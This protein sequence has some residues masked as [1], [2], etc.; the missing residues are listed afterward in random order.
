[1]QHNYGWQWGWFVG[2]WLLLGCTLTAQATHIVGGDLSLQFLGAN[3]PSTHRITLNFYFD[4]VNGNAT[5]RNTE[6]EVAIFSKRTNQLITT[7]T[8]PLSSTSL[9]SYSNQTCSSQ[10]V[11]TQLLVYTANVSLLPA[12]YNDAGGYYISWERCCRNNVITNIINPGAAGSAF[13]LEFPA[14]T[15]NGQPFYDSSPA[16]KPIIGDYACINT[17]F[18][19]D[20]S[21]T[22]ADGD[23]LAYSMVTPYNGFSSSLNPLPSAPTGLGQQPI[24]YAGPYPDVAWS[25]GINATNSIPGTIPLRVNSRTGLLTLV[26]SRTGL[27][28]FSV[29]VDE[30]RAGVKIGVVRRDFQ[31]LVV[32]CPKNAAPSI[33]L[34]VSGQTKFYQEGNVLTIT[35]ADTNC[36]TL[37]TTDP[38]ISQI[39]TVKNLSGSLPGL[40]VG[41]SSIT[42]RT[43][44]DTLITQFCF[45]RCVARPD[46]KPVT[47]AILATDN[48]CPQGRADTLYVTLNIIAP[49]Y[50]KPA[51]STNL[52]GNAATVSVGKSLSFTAFGT[53]MDNDQMTLTAVGRGFALASANMSFSTVT[54]KSK[55]TGPF[56]WTPQC[57]QGQK[58]YVVDFI[59]SKNRCNNPMSDTVTVQLTAE[60]LPSL[61]PTVTTTQSPTVVTISLPAQA[62]ANSAL[63]FDVLGN[64]TDSN[65]IKLTGKGRGFD[66]RAAG[67]TFTDKTGQP[68]L[69]STFS[70]T[71]GCAQLQGRD[72]TTYFLDFTA[73]DGSCGPNH[74]VTTSIQ[75]NLVSPPIESVLKMPNVFTPNGDG[76]NDGFSAI[77]LPSENCSEQFQYIEIV[78]RWGQQVFRSP[79]P[80]FVWQADGFPAGQYF[81]HIQ[82]TK[83]DYK[84]SI[85]LLK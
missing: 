8:L 40:S 43:Q 18:S 30:F 84:G 51:A 6:V 2:L 33:N 14:L 26:A 12:T 41:P 13:Y 83:T 38:D 17:P 61:P 66:M 64:D 45:G 21:A 55:I 27:F 72:S 54:G 5:A 35:E 82:Y 53:D 29:Q 46:G 58:V 73:D 63:Q 74:A 3:R 28:V 10:S 11:Q 71:P 77:N 75:V 78:N 47:L 76:K 20:F 24:F 81:Y 23:S 79:D 39:V 62:G 68:Q 80:K 19:F 42:I 70:W 22:D 60:S 57:A 59:V 31:L 37:Y 50:R 44:S 32:D 25:A 69:R 85:T 15:K 56:S 65:P 48:A 34:R 52:P 7:Y 4:L 16:F 36:L 67:A 9:V 1:M 49:P